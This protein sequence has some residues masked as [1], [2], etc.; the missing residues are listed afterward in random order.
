MSVFICPH[1]H[2]RFTV[3]QSTAAG[4]VLCPHC[5]QTVALP[6]PTPSRWYYARAKKKH[7]PYTW[8]QLLILAQRGDLRSDDMLLQEGTKQW[9][10]AGTLPTLFADA[11]TSPPAGAVG[12]SSPPATK[13]RPRL[14]FGLAI[15]GMTGAAAC[16]VLSLIIA[17]YFVFAG[18]KQPEAQKAKDNQFTD[19]KKQ[20]APKDVVDSAT[21]DAA[22]LKKESKIDEKENSPQKKV[23]PAPPHPEWAAQ[24]VERLNDYRKRTG[25][26]SVT[27]DAELSRGCLAHA[28]YLARHIDPFK[29]EAA[30]LA[31][32]DPKKPGFSA[33]GQQ[34]GQNAMVAFAAPVVALE[35]WMGRLFSRVAVLTPQMQ[36]V[37]IGYA[38]NER[39]DWICVVDPVR[40]RGEPVVVFPAPN[41]LDVPRSFTAGAEVPDSKAAAGFPITVTLPSARKVSD[42]RIE[43]RDEK[44]KLVEAWIWTPEKPVP[45]GRQHNTITLIPKGLLH[46][47]AIYQVKAS[48][49]V[50]AKPWSLAWSFT[51]VDDRDTKGI[52]AKKALA[53]VNA[54]R[55]KAG[56]KPVELDDKLSRGCLAHARYLV[57]NEGHPALQGLNAHDEDEKLPGFSEEGRAAGKASDLGIG[58]IEPIDSVDAWMATLYHR[59]PIL[60]PNLKT[61]GFGCARGRRQGWVTVMNVLSGQVKTDRPHA[62]FYPASDQ[63]GVPL[64]FPNSGEE[65]NPIPED[66]T[67]RAGYPI[68]VFFPHAEPLKDATGK[69]IDSRGVEVPCWFSSP[70]RRANPNAQQGNTVCLIPKAP[71][72]PVASYHVQIHGQIAGK[73]WEKKWKFTTGEAGMSV[74][75]AAQLVVSRVNSY[76]AQAGLGAVALDEKLSYGCR[77]HAEYLAKNA[78]TLL[79]TKASVN[80]ENA[81]LPGFTAEGLRAARQSD[82]FTNAPTPVMQIDDLM[83]TFSRRVYLLHPNLQR[84]GFGCFHDVG[85]GW[86]CVLDLNGG[87]GDSRVVVYPVANQDDV[88][89]IGFDI[90]Q[91]AKGNPGFPISVA[92]PRQV[93]L[94]NA[95]ALLL[96]S[97]GKSV[98]ILISSP[99]KPLNDK[100]QLGII[101][102]HPL[103][104][105]HAGQVYTVT[106]S[107]V[108]DGA[109]WRQT[110]QFTTAKKK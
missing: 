41:Q 71:L 86:R 54:Y 17:G 88:P 6:K 35:K 80:D 31:E 19:A 7:G 5:R 49:Q 53:K 21:K 83:A 40:G 57:M 39:G 61:I 24:F 43:L 9:V 1:C 79:K 75:A 100:L 66:K 30:Q 97:D 36:S 72:M 108:I 74:S 47:G 22:L 98:E 25:L 95:R 73:A 63:T 51:T 33:L 81:N 28:N 65:P 69:L 32:E 52:W 3:T 93:N 18:G 84:I 104:P 89:T 110:W 94:R 90:L 99:E 56:L 42:V 103:E 87:R 20:E 48:A 58:D 16:A 14:A 50:D 55:T 76:R 92:F 101:G 62:V 27:L 37:G 70:Q 82:V 46:S 59:V 4:H 8:P 78:E 38:S 102:V 34:A 106:V 96:D 91:D 107:I 85:R 109:E 68:T 64:N 60:E 26:G 2:K 45:S 11:G 105:L 77:L 29:V 23:P 10:P 67:G 13:K 44:N 12:K 15:A